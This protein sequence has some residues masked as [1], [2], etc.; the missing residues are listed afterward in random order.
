M[1]DR[2]PIDEILRRV[3]RPYRRWVMWIVHLALLLIGSVT[4]LTLIWMLVP[5]TQIGLASSSAVGFSTL[6]FVLLMLHLAT[7]IVLNRRDKAV[8]NALLEMGYAIPY[9]TKRD[10]ATETDAYPTHLSDDGEL[11]Y[12]DDYEIDEE[13]LLYNNR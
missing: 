11:A 5:A 2:P 7:V 10:S 1:G 6:W 3:E 9:K 13:A 4:L 12:D 8:L